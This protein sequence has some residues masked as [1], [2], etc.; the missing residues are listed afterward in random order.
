MKPWAPSITRPN[1]QDPPRKSRV[2]GEQVVGPYSR[3]GPYSCKY[4]KREIGGVLPLVLFTSLNMLAESSEASVF[5]SQSLVQE[6]H[7]G[8][9]TWAKVVRCKYKIFIQSTSLQR[10]RAKNGMHN[11]V[12]S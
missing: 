10:Q 11:I 6:A 4:I 3:K 7:F 12:A 9:G 1:R 2:I 5:T 8:P